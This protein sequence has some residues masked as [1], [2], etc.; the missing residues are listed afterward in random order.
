MLSKERYFSLLYFLEENVMLINN[1][2]REIY[3][4]YCKSGGLLLN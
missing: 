1:K 2:I 4:Y 3:K